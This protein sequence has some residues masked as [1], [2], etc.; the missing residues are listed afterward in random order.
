[1]IPVVSQPTTSPISG[2]YELVVVVDHVD[3]GGR[4]FVKERDEGR[5]ERRGETSPDQ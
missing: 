5:E 3:W 1:M 2:V 4:N